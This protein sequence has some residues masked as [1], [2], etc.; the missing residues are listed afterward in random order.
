MGGTSIQP[1]PAPDL[2]A[3][4]VVLGQDRQQ[5][6]VG[7]LPDAPPLVLRRRVA[8]DPEEHRGLA[9]QVPLEPVP[10]EP[11]AER[12]PP[13]QQVPERGH[14]RHPAQHRRPQLGDGGREEVRPVEGA[15]GLHSRV[16]GG[17]LLAEVEALLLVG[18][19]G[20][21][22]PAEG[23][24]APP[25]PPG[26]G[27]GQLALVRRGQGEEP[28]RRAVERG[29]QRGIDAVAGDAEEARVA[30]GGIHGP[31]HSRHRV[32]AGIAAPQRAHVDDGH[33]GR[34]V[35]PGGTGT[36]SGVA[37]PRGTRRRAGRRRS[38]RAGAAGRRRRAAPGPGAT[39]G[40]R[41]P[42]SSAG[43]TRRCRAPPVA[44]ARRWPSRSAAPAAAGPSAAAQRTPPA[45]A[46]RHARA[47]PRPARAQPARARAQ[48]ARLGRRGCSRRGCGCRRR[49]CGC[50]RGR[51]RHSGRR[52]RQ[53]RHD[54]R[55]QV[56]DD[57]RR[58][59]VRVGPLARRLR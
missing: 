16:V 42:P 13:Q 44:G 35:H 46:A 43:A 25:C 18:P 8:E 22:L 32:G 7:V 48:Q 56:R 11:E 27:H 49:G 2:E 34:H 9:G 5:P 24:P 41:C 52:R 12:H 6:V 26:A 33:A 39:A 3:A 50:G 19:A 38:P 4:A 20:G 21:Q 23:E 45:V 57:G 51:R 14:G 30:A 59:P 58:Q 53:V 55:R 28:A 15:P 47:W 10:L 36:G 31:R 37:A 1:L 54:G 17:Q 40:V 29:E